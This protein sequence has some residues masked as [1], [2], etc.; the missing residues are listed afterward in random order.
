MKVQCT[1]CDKINELP[2]DSFEAKRLRNRQ[3]SMYLCKECH[4]RI[5]ENTNKR[6]N[7][8]NFRL[9]REKKKLYPF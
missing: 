7:T 8:G 4:N 5:T 1:I 6:L 3:T 2:G 9:F